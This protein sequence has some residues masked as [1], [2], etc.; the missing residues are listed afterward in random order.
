[1]FDKF[2]RVG[3]EQTRKSKGTGLG[4]FIVKKLVDFHKGT[5]QVLNNQPRGTNFEITFIV[6]N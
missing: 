4:L 6:I 3:D 5:I 2:F 1:L